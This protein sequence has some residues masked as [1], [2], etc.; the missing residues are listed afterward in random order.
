MI[1]VSSTAI[2]E[3]K[4]CIKCIMIMFIVNK[5]VFDTKNEIHRSVT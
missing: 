5:N 4:E 3:M 2:L 1:L